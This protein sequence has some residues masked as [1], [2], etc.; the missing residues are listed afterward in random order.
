MAILLYVGSERCKFVFLRNAETMKKR[1]HEIL[2]YRVRTSRTPSFE[3]SAS[4]IKF[5][6]PN[7]PLKLPLARTPLP[8]KSSFLTNFSFQPMPRMHAGRRGAGAWQFC[9]MGGGAWQFC[10]TA[11]Y[12]KWSRRFCCRP[13]LTRGAG[14]RGVAIL[15]YGAAGRAKLLLRA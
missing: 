4:R 10:S 15:F 9:S 2:D 11:W 5:C 8:G 7:V 12:Q 3:N 14:R 1:Q 6:H 13:A